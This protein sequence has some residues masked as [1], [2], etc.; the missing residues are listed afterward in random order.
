[1]KKLFSIC[2]LMTCS[3]WISAQ[4]TIKKRDQD[5]RNGRDGSLEVLVANASLPIKSFVWNDGVDA[6][7]RMNVPAGNYCVTVTDANDCTGVDCVT[8]EQPESALTLTIEVAPDPVTVPCGV[9]QPVFVSAF[10]NGGDFPYSIN[11]KAGATYTL[12]VSE[13]TTVRF[14][15]K[16]KNGCV[17]EKEIRVYVLPRICSFDPN[18]IV[19]P[20][21]YDSLQWVSVRDTLDYSIKFEND[22]AL[23]TAPAQRVMITHHFDDDI[24]PYS[25]R[26]GSF[27][28]GDFIFDVPENKSFHQTRLDLIAEIGLYVDVIAGIDVS[29]NSAFWIF[30]SIDPS[31]GLLPI[32]PLIGFLPVND[33]TTRGGE[34]FANFFVRPKLP[35]HTGDTILAQAKIFFDIN[36]PII[37]NIWTNTIDALPPATMLDPIPPTFENDTIPLSWNGADDPGGSGLDIYELYFSKDHAAYQRYEETFPDSILS[38]DFVG[39]FGSAY[40]FYIIGIDHTGNKE[41]ANPGEISTTILPRKVI[42][43]IQPVADEYCIRDTFWVQWSLREIDT[44]DVYLSV[45]SGFTFQPLFTLRPSMDTLA[46]FIIPDS[47]AAAYIQISITDHTDTTVVRSSILPFKGLPVVDAGPDQFICT[48][49][50]SFLIP[51]GGNQYSWSPDTFINNP[52]LT[53]PTIFPVEDIQYHVE[54]TDVFGCRNID[55]INIFIHPVFLDSVTH[56]MCN[57]DSV[58]LE[59]DYR[60]EPGYYTDELASVNGCDSTVVTEVIL[61]GPCPFPA[62][63]VYVD[64]DATGLNNGTSWANAFTD[65]QDALEAVE[66]YLDVTD[67]WVAEGDYYPSVP[68]GRNASFTLRDSVKIFGGFLGIETMLEDRTGNET[69]VKL[70]GDLGVPNDSLDNAYQVIRIDTSCVDCVI[71]SLTIRFGQGDGISE[72]TYGAGLFVEGILTLDG[73]TV[74]RNTTL[75]EGAA[76]YNSGSGTLLTIRDCLF[77]LNSSSLARD[78]LNTNGAEIRFEGMNTVED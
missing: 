62:D 51:G 11:G 60:T 19:G 47:L 4:V 2:L 7:N 68:V 59:G 54:G 30:E 21:G 43:L 39:E 35:G 73:V 76:I 9:R 3:I 27:G 26:L 37:T 20:V 66:Y 50:Y 53:V 1:M 5:C 38:F 33:T 31:T 71:N 46:Y 65:L 29:T 42:E 8:I 61:T 23:A 40:S 16:D 55:S 70:S 22:P 6:Q 57:E 45:D 34:G 78:I 64:K 25:F 17:V 44:V 28:W 67:I 13:T 52:N 14:Q 12:R 56:L 24:N 63:Q 15:L 36:E 48:G 10:A 49:D 18:E 69:I 41:N 77:R 58:F 72:Q 74:E 75:L 32:N